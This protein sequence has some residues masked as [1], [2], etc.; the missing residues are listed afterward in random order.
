MCLSDR[1]IIQ[2]RLYIWTEHSIVT[3]LQREELKVITLSFLHQPKQSLENI[4]KNDF[5]RMSR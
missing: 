2:G 3:I 5:L 4:K 1:A